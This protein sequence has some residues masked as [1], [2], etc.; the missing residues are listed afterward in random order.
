MHDEGVS[1]DLS[2][3]MFVNKVNLNSI[4]D[5]NNK[6]FLKLHMSFYC[7]AANYKYFLGIKSR[8]VL[9]L[10]VSKKS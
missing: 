4:L 5:V 1:V 10:Q 9:M 8:F 2:N 6:Y 3:H 7:S